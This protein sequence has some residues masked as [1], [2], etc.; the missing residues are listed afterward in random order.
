MHTDPPTHTPPPPSTNRLHVCSGSSGSTYTATHALRAMFYAFVLPMRERQQ[1]ECDERLRRMRRKPAAQAPAGGGAAVFGAALSRI[2]EAQAAGGA[3]FSDDADCSQ[4]ER[5]LKEDDAEAQLQEG[6][7]DKYDS[8]DL[9]TD[10]D[11][12]ICSQDGDYEDDSSEE[13]SSSDCSGEN[14]GHILL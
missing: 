11:A 5:D 14:E 7:P 12:R 1:G 13:S 4:D 9:A 6:R 8:D 3:E 2:P 10:D